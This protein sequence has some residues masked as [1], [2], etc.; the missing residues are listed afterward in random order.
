[1]KGAVLG[2]N[3]KVRYL[4]MQNIASNI[5]CVAVMDHQFERAHNEI[6]IDLNHEVH[7][8]TRSFYT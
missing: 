8:R 5:Y 7:P 1:M 6:Q 2:A 3:H 4:G